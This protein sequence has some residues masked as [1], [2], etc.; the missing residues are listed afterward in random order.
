MPFDLRNFLQNAKRAYTVRLAADLSARDFD[1]FCVPDPADCV[2]G[3]V[4][5]LEGAE[6]TLQ[7]SADVRAECARCLAPVQEHYEFTRA[8][9]VRPRDLD[10]PD[11]E[12]PLDAQG[13][14][15]IEELI[16][17]ELIFEVPRVLLCSPDCL[18]LCPICG[19]KRAA[20]CTCQPAE[21]AA[22]PDARLSILKQL[23]S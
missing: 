22:P 10:D 3:A 18:G 1:G 14:M 20:G 12:L 15:E 8:Y 2:F 19:K 6:L 17:Q 4:P 16:Y 7:V 23:L 5:T 13:C 21:D 9:T 11:C